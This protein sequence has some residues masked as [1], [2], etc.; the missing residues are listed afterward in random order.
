MKRQLILI[1]FVFF[2][3]LLRVLPHPPNF[4]PVTA[5]ALFSGVYFSN[6]YLAIIV[7]ILA[8]T[9]S[10]IVLGFYSISY[11]V[12]GSFILVTVF[13]MVA[14]SIKIKSIL[15]SSLIFFFFSNLGVWILGYPKTLEGFILCYTL[16][17]PFLTYSLLGDLF[18]SLVLKKSFNYV[19]NRWLTTVY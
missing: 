5:L 2:A 4:A 7:P 10:D 18:F 1:L 14:K 3:A 12:Y 13:G 11:W 16:A 9:L 17:I 8:M 15:I 6:R 19:E